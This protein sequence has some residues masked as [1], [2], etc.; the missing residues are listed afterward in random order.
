MLERWVAALG[1]QPARSV[2]LCAE[3]LAG[4][5]VQPPPIYEAAVRR[6][7]EAGGASFLDLVRLMRGLAGAPAPAMQ[8]VRMLRAALLPKLHS[9]AGLAAAR[10]AAGIAKNYSAVVAATLP[11]LERAKLDV[12]DERVLRKA[13]DVF[14]EGVGGGGK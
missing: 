2:C 5:G 1:T 12:E 6:V 4:L 11:K 7:V 14:V 13:V 9:V 8:H 10:D 3:P